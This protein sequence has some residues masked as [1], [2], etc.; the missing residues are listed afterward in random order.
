[1]PR[2]RMYVDREGPRNQ[3]LQMC[4]YPLP[5]PLTSSGRFGWQALMHGCA[6]HCS[7]VSAAIRLHELS[8]TSTARFKLPTMIVDAAHGSH[9]ARKLVKNRPVLLLCLI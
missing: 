6:V 3:R 8:N 5:L 4:R 1:M 7:S 9:T 2:W